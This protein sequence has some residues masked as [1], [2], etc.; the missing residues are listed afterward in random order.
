[1]DFLDT[2]THISFENRWILVHDTINISHD[3][4]PTVNA[5]T[6]TPILD[7]LFLYTLLGW[8]VFQRE[9]SQFHQTDAELF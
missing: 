7:I 8:T 1:M 4:S 6:V 5:G 3:L 9:L 2:F